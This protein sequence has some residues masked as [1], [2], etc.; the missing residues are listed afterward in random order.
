MAVTVIKCDGYWHLNLK[1]VYDMESL[2]N[3][4]KFCD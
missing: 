2:T 1:V 4:I 3:L